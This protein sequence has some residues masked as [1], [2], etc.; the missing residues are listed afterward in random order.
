[1]II[2]V[3]TSHV[4]RQNFKTT[5]IEDDNY[6]VSTVDDDVL[7]SKI[8]LSVSRRNRSFNST[9]VRVEKVVRVPNQAIGVFCN[10]LVVANFKVFPSN[11]AT[12]N[13]ST[14]KDDLN[15]EAVYGIMIVIKDCKLSVCTYY[16]A[17]AVRSVELIWERGK[18]ICRAV[19]IELGKIF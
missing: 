4:S 1:M 10:G 3:T 17:D 19:D 11:V 6:A 15:Y 9:V 13:S 2:T 7:F 16:L 12:F 18:E 5:L 14:V 8:N